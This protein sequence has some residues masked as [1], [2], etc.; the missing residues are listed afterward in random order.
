MI[1]MCLAE[2]IDCVKKEY[3]SLK[4]CPLYMQKIILKPKLKQT[5]FMV[6][7]PVF[8]TWLK[9]SEI[10]LNKVGKSH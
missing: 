10:A 2:C 5:F 4:K 9:W 7:F 1:F 3:I 8:V 6:Y